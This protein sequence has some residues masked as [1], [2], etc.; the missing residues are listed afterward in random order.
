MDPTTSDPNSQ[1]PSTADADELLYDE[2]RV[3]PL[4][5]QCWAGSGYGLLVRRFE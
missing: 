5:R 4:R 3:E 2:L 1:M